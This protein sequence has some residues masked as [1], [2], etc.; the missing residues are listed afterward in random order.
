MFS[1]MSSS[2]NLAPAWSHSF[3]HN[4]LKWQLFYLPSPY[5]PCICRQYRYPSG[6]FFIFQII[7]PPTYVIH[8]QLWSSKH[9]IIPTASHLCSC[10][11]C[12]SHLHNLN[13]FFPD[14][15]K[16][17][18]ILLQFLSPVSWNSEL[19]TYPIF[20]P[21]F[22]IVIHSSFI[23]QQRFQQ[24]SIVQLLWINQALRMQQTGRRD[25]NPCPNIFCILI[26]RKRQNIMK[27]VKFGS[28]FH[29][30]C[31]SCKYCNFRHSSID[32]LII[33]GSRLQQFFYLEESYNSLMKSFVSVV[34]T[35]YLYSFPLCTA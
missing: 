35:Y 22:P 28:C 21:L 25:K 23:F 3:S 9:Q 24:R 7:L 8:P 33:R 1:S 5:F 34:L 10:P 27:L 18:C 17:S 15:F 12:P 4:S 2:W 13:F 19:F 29:N 14:L 31:N 16:F 26:E 30:N 11:S 6:F 20:Q 32:M